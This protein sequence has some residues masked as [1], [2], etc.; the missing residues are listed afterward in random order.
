MFDKQSAQTFDTHREVRGQLG[1]VWVWVCV[2]IEWHA[3]VNTS[4][5]SSSG[6][7]FIESAELLELFKS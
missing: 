4:I 1:G 6:I 3:I 5:N 2:F 7:V